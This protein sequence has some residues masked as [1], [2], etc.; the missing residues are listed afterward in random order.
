MINTSVI[1]FRYVNKSSVYLS[2]LSH[3]IGV[4][5]FQND[6]TQTHTNDRHP[7]DCEANINSQCACE[8]NVLDIETTHTK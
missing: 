8:D 6:R 3:N 7:P 1:F 2:V 4:P 5:L